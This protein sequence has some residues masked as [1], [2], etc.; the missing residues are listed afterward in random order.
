MLL[1]SPSKTFRTNLAWFSNRDVT[2]GGRYLKMKA[3]P[4]Q[5]GKTNNQHLICMTC[6]Y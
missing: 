3:K 1:M 2:G 4:T 6:S 5:Y